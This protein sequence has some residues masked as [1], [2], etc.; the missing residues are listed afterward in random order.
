MSSKSMQTSD[1]YKISQH[2][3]IQQEIMF[4]TLEIGKVY[5]QLNN[6]KDDLRTAVSFFE[7]SHIA[8]KFAESNIKTI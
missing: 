7:C 6:M 3:F 2:V 1:A 4:K 5:E 8:N